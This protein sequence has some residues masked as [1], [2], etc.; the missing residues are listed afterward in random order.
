MQP[1][2]FL[3]VVIAFLWAAEALASSNPSAYR[4][5]KA[6]LDIEVLVKVI[7]MF[8]RDFG[9][10]PTDAE[11]LDVLIM[12][13]PSLD[14]AVYPEGGY[15]KTL[16]RDPWG[17]EYQYLAQGNRNSGGF[18]VFT[19][20]AD[21]QPGGT[22]INADAG[23]WPGSFA[24][25][26]ELRRREFWRGVVQMIGGTAL[27]G[28]LIGLPPYLFAYFRKRKAGSQRGDAAKGL[29][30]SLLIYLIL[31]MPAAFSLAALVLG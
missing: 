16:P 13:T 11:G 19:F 14:M 15:I 12:P 28:F 25:L 8:H 30:L 6:K 9:R 26:E 22:G 10:Y 2:K 20:G 31:I 18:E 24:H 1:I 7:E 4:Q 17:N 27:F 3:S 29:H 23:N 5:T 21:G